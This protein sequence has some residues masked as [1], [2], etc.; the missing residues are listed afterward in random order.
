M[1]AGR[2]KYGLT[3][4]VYSFRYDSE[5]L[6]SYMYS[7]PCLAI[8]PGAVPCP[9]RRGKRR[10]GGMP[11]AFQPGACQCDVICI[12]STSDFSLGSMHTGLPPFSLCL[13][14]A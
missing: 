8:A 2:E 12:L 10:A 4:A 1:G 3:A 5:G 7:I 9:R 14:V 11:D 6:E 13:V